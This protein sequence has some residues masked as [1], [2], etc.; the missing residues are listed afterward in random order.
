[1][2]EWQPIDTVPDDVMTV[3]GYSPRG[4]QEGTPCI[5]QITYYEG[6]GNTGWWEPVDGNRFYPTH[7]MPLPN[8]PL[9]QKE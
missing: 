5:A 9:T 8:P 3:L 6:N 7:W 4:S 1:M 2:T